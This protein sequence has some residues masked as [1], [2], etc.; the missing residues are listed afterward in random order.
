MGFRVDPASVPT[1]RTAVFKGPSLA[2]LG[3]GAARLW[4]V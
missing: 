4:V 1:F 3:H 2:V